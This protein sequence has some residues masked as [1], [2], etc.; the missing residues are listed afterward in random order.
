MNRA[1]SL[2]P[3]IIS[4]VTQHLWVYLVATVFGA[5]TTSLIYKL[6]HE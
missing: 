3:A 2:G 4:G 1:R 5:I 6:L